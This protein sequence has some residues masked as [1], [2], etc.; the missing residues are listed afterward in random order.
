MAAI[1]GDYF[2]HGWSWLFHNNMIFLKINRLFGVKKRMGNKVSKLVG[3]LG[4]LRI[5]ILPASKDDGL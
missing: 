4:I 2:P 3:S 5:I 1:I